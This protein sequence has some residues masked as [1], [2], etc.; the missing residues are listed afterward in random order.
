MATLTLP[1]HADSDLPAWARR[2]SVV[3]QP[4]ALTVS[5]RQHVP[6]ERAVAWTQALLQHFPAQRVRVLCSLQ[7]HELHGSRHSGGASCAQYRVQTAAAAAAVAAAWQSSTATAPL[8]PSGTLVLGL[9]AALM[10]RCQAS[11]L[12]AACSQI[13]WRQCFCTIQQTEPE[14]LSGCAG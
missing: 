6:P 11:G 13:L 1:K 12:V 8:L 9:P 5:C 7:P 3:A 4:G 2:A 14:Q 10:S